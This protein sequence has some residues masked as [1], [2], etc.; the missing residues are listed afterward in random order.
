MKR[1]EVEVDNQIPKSETCDYQP[2]RKFHMYFIIP[3]ALISL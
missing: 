1:G 3:N 2:V